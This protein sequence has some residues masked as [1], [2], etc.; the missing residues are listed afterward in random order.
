MRTIAF[1]L[2]AFG[3][4]AAA[5][6][7]DIQKLRKTAKAPKELAVQGLVSI[8][9]TCE[10]R[11][12]PEIDLDIPPKGGTVCMRP[13]LVRLS[14]TWTGNNQHC[15][16]KRISGVF[17]IYLP[18]GSFIGLDTMQYTVRVEPPQ[19]RTYEAEIRVE[20]GHTIIG[21]RSTPSEPQKAGPMPVCPAFVS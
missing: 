2:A 20:A 5:S 1:G 10:S 4:V 9:D 12:L 18:F 14:S 15:I 11:D 17:V 7:Q 3:L 16:G 19:T 13:G 21:P 6:A 8:D